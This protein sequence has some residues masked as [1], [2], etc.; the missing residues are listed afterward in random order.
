MP[1]LASENQYDSVS[2]FLSLYW[3]LLGYVKLMTHTP[4][5]GT[6][7]RRRKSAPTSGLCVIPIWYQIFLVPDSGA[8]RPPEHASVLYRADFWD[9]RD[10]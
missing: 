2:Q 6:E 7:N 9:V 8:G 5:I 4:E 10:R 3:L 1:S